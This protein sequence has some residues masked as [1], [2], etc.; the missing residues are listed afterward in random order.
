MKLKSQLEDALQGQESYKS[1]VKRIQLQ[2]EV[3]D[4][5]EGFSSPYSFGDR[6]ESPAQAPA[7]KA[8]NSSKKA[9]A[10]FK[11]GTH[12]QLIDVSQ[13]PLHE[14]TEEV[15]FSD[16]SLFENGELSNRNA[17]KS[18]GKQHHAKLPTVPQDLDSY[19]EMKLSHILN[20]QGESQDTFD[21]ENLLI[22]S[23]Q[24]KKAPL[25]ESKLK[26]LKKEN[27]QLREQVKKLKDLLS[28]DKVLKQMKVEYNDCL[29]ECRR[30]LEHLENKVQ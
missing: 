4:V 20:K 14:I 1:L 9:L 28:T 5:H 23:Q 22:L 25:G 30:I 11:E 8:A 24:K 7:I 12:S 16:T 17:D 21:A 19:S 26:A 3:N 15:R 6:Q 18:P 2:R 29:Q 27:K 10:P 13:I